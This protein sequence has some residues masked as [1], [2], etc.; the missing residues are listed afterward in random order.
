M[1]ARL[2]RPAHVSSPVL[3]L[4]EV[5]NAHV[6]PDITSVLT[7]R[8]AKVILY[9][10][11]SVYLYDS[12]VRGRWAVSQKRTMIPMIRRRLPT[13]TAF[14]PCGFI[15]GQV[16]E[17]LPWVPETFHARFPVSVKS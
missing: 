13:N 4:L 7:A 3:T 6:Q 14:F 17:L 12:E 2:T 8:N 11:V 10:M 15:R 1:S 5:T 16:G 9:K